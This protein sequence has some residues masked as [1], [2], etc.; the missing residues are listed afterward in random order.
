MSAA[1][2]RSDAIRAVDGPVREAGGADGL[3]GVFGDRGEDAVCAWIG[4]PGGGG[5][6]ISV[7][8]HGG[9]ADRLSFLTGQLQSWKNDELIDAGRRPWPACPRP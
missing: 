2:Q 3:S 5:E 9:L 6:G 7:E 1:A 8:L 4:H